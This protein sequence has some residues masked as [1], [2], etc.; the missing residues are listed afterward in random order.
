MPASVPA[1]PLQKKE[2]RRNAHSLFYALFS[3]IS[4]TKGGFLQKCATKNGKIGL[5]VA[6][7]MDKLNK[8]GRKCGAV[9]WNV[10]PNAIKIRIW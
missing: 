6:Y 1:S 9:G 4:A 10:L 7:F 2:C 8:F 3:R 5:L